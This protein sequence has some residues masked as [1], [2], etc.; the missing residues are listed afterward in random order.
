LDV[1]VLQVPE[2]W[3]PVEVRGW[4]SFPGFTIYLPLGWKYPEPRLSDEY[5]RPFEGDGMR[6]SLTYGGG[7]QQDHIVVYDTDPDQ[8]ARHIVSYEN[9]GGHVARLVRPRDGEGRFTSVYIEDRPNITIVATEL[10]PKQQ[11]VAFTIFRS[12]RDLGGVLEIDITLEGS[13]ADRPP[14]PPPPPP[15]IND[16]GPS[17]EVYDAAGAWVQAKRVVRSGVIEIFL[18]RGSYLIAFRHPDDVLVE[19]LPQEVTMEPQRKIS[20][21]VSVKP[22]R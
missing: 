3:Q 10:S 22:I 12:I 14:G 17:I 6:F 15:G 19:G 1:P 5:N 13:L 2:D 18:R 7:P 11:A 8:V 21:N 9:I 20:I 16:P 4:P